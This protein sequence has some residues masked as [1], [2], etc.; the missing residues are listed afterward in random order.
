MDELTGKVVVIT[1]AGAGMGR[2]TARMFG[3]RGAKVIAADISG[4]ERDLAEEFGAAILP[5]HC[6]VGKEGQVE[7][8][9][10][11]AVSHFG[12]LDAVLNVAGFGIPAMLAEADMADY[13]RMLDVDLRGV[14]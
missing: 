3:A 14:I 4:G 10:A 1:G 11:P 9:I 2:A 7:A 5:V 13:D 6:D 8:M 12:R